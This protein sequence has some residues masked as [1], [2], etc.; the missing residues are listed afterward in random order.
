MA[1][2]KV[3]S[4]VLTLLKLTEIAERE[5]EVIPDA[6]KQGKWCNV[7]VTKNEILDSDEFEE[8]SLYQAFV[9]GLI[10]LT[11]GSVQ[12]PTSNKG[13]RE[14][15]LKKAKDEEA[16]KLEGN[17]DVKASDEEAEEKEAKAKSKKK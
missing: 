10:E 7:V 16:E 15:A 14:K 17:E 11:G 9:N 12:K 8:A 13:V 4:R 2:Y 3:K 5:N 6:W 1:K